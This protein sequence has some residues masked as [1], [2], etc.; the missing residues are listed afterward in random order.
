[1]FPKKLDFGMFRYQIRVIVPE[2]G[3]GPF[4]TVGTGGLQG[5]GDESGNPFIEIGSEEKQ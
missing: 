2:I 1:M 5:V 3:K 4:E